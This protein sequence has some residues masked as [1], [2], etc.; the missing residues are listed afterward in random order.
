MAEAVGLALAVLPLIISAIEHYGG[1]TRP[2][3]R[4]RDFTSRARHFH[5]KLNTQR[6]IFR[7]QCRLLLLEIVEQEIATEM[8]NDQRHPCWSSAQLDQDLKEQINASQDS[9]V[10]VLQEI[11]AILQRLQKWI[12]QLE[13]A[14]EQDT[15]VSFV[16]LFRFESHANGMK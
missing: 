4:Y 6:T 11:G 15:K 12:D 1:C 16:S 3:S 5:Q 10:G 8:M 13:F 14:L 7:N 9:C 2:F